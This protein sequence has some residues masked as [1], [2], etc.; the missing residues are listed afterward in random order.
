MFMRK[1]ININFNVLINYL[2]MFYNNYVLSDKNEINIILK[3]KLL[4]NIIMF[5]EI[6]NNQFHKIMKFIVLQNFLYKM[7]L[8]LENSHATL[9]PL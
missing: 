5:E 7:I 3:L 2:Y 1:K 4:K 9:I 6:F 8:K